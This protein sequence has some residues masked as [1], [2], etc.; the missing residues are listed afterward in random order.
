[1]NVEQ[2]R[3]IWSEYSWERHGEEWSRYWGTTEVLWKRTIFPRIRPLLRSAPAG[4]VLEIACGHG[5]MTRWLLEESRGYVGIDLMKECVDH[6][7][8]RFGEGPSRKFWQ[9][10]GLSLEAVARKS[11]AFAFSWGSLVHCD[12]Q[13]MIAYARELDRVMVDGGFAFLHHSNLRPLAGSYPPVADPRNT[14]R[15]RDPTVNAEW[16]AEFCRA[17]IGLRVRLQEKVGWGADGFV[18]CLTVLR[19]GGGENT[20]EIERRDFMEEARA[21]RRLVEIEQNYT[22]AGKA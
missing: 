10:D 8:K 1:M 14:P 21:V 4:I 5:R 15:L 3:K 7:R 17:E 16:F 11:V 6:C 2:N 13:T 9:C 18:D 22:K 20:V 19:K 12:D